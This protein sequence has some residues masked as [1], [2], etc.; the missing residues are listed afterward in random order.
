MKN[1]KGQANIIAIIGM[2]AAV[3]FVMLNAFNYINSVGLSSQISI[4]AENS[5]YQTLSVKDYLIQQAHYLFDKAQL[6]DAFT[7]NP[8]TSSLN[9]GY[10]NTTTRLPFI[11]VDKVFYWRNLNGQTCLPNNQEIMYGLVQLLNQSQFS[12]VNSSGLNIK[13]FLDLNFTKT[14]GR[15]LFKAEFTAP[16]LSD[17][18]DMFYNRSNATNQSVQVYDVGKVNCN[19]DN[20]C[21]P[22]PIE[23]FSG[24]VGSMFTLNQSQFTVLPEDDIVTGVLS[25]PVIKSTFFQGTVGSLTSSSSQFTIITLSNGLS[26]AVFDKQSLSGGKTLTQFFMVPLANP[27]V[28]SIETAIIADS[29][30]GLAPLVTL[31]NNT[32]FEFGG[33]WYNFTVTTYPNGIFNIIP[34]NYSIVPLQPDFVYY[35]YIINQFD[36]SGQQNLL[37]PNHQPLRVSLSLFPLY[38]PEVCL[39]YNEIQFT[40]QNCISV[41]GYLTTSDYISQLMQLGVAFVNESFP[42]GNQNITGFAQYALYNY[43]NNVVHGVNLKTVSVN[44]QPKYDWY[45][46]LLLAMGSIQHGAAYLINELNPVAEPYY[47]TIVYNCSKSSSDMSYCQNLL[48]KTIE[49]DLRNLLEYQVPIEVSFLSGS[50]FDINVL[51]LSV[52]VREANSCPNYAGYSSKQ[53]NAT[54]NYS[55]YLKPEEFNNSSSETLGVPISLNFGYQNTLNL[56]PTESCGISN[57]PYQRGYPGFSQTLVSQNSTT[58]LNCAQ[59]LAHAF[60][61]TTCIASVETSD[62]NV[63][64]YIK[65]NGGS[66]TALVGSTS[67]FCNGGPLDVNAETQPGFYQRWLSESNSCPNYVF[68]DNKNFTYSQSA[69]QYKLVS[70]YGGGSY[71]PLDIPANWTFSSINRSNLGLPANFSVYAGVRVSGPS[72]SFNLILSKDSYLG[73]QSTIFQI[74]SGGNPNAVYNYV[75]NTGNFINIGTS[76]YSAQ[77]NAENNIEIDRY[78]TISLGYDFLFTVNSLLQSKI[79][80]SS[81]AGGQTIFNNPVNFLGFSTDNRPASDFLDYFFIA[82]YANGYNPI[83]RILPYNAVSLL[84]SKLYGAFDLKNKNTTYYN[85]ILLNPAQFS[86]NYQVKIVLDYNFNYAALFAFPFIKVFGYYASTNSTVQ[87]AWWNQTPIQNGGILWVNPGKT[88]PTSLYIVYG[89]GAY[90]MSGYSDSGNMVFPLFFSNSSTYYPFTFSYSQNGKNRPTLVSGSLNLVRTGP[91]AD[92]VY[93]STLNEYYAQF[94][95]VTLKPSF[96]LEILNAT[97]SPYPQQ[98]SI[99]QLYGD[100]NAAYPDLQ[101]ISS[102]SYNNWPS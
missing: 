64:T 51:N 98:F 33:T 38:N 46:A 30:A 7:V 40:L 2:V 45:S 97:Y 94:A 11:P 102:K 25:Q 10:I 22:A 1:K 67:D 8:T 69:D 21:L 54:V 15:G 42:L 47:G 88:M 61:N 81:V 56:A 96:N 41:S 71:S 50:P 59:V 75:S 53:Y 3:I 18:Y 60:L 27:N 79:D 23:V 74:N 17:Q 76:Q 36:L 83:N 92:Y 20:S 70:I 5:I 43:I 58:Y 87:M 63:I 48:S 12:L 6:F 90:D 4:T 89:T 52:N 68:I 39:S 91:F 34:E 93:N 49:E 55:Y 13:S 19:L 100:Y 29:A 31:I 26:A 62:S 24:M 77:A 85:Q 35:K 72:P 28:Y 57:N 16:Y 65:N 73:A 101:V 32:A 9:C 86:S 95:C 66:C 37:F 99:N 84:S 80:Y 14:A 82:N 78:G 44:G